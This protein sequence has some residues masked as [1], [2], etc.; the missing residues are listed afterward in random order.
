MQIYR[1]AKVLGPWL[2]SRLRIANERGASA[3]EY[4]IM[5]VLIAAVVII[6]VAALG[7]GTS[8]SFDCTRQ[9]IADRGATTC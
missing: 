9:R 4:G 6:A 2:V 5:I 3:V 7:N 8:A 1:S